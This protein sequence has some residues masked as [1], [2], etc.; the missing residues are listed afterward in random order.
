MYKE[1]VDQVYSQVRDNVI[2]Q[3]RDD[4]SLNVNVGVQNQIW[5][6]VSEIVSDPVI[7][8]FMEIFR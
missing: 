3:G 1:L 2:L 5:I 6:N 4:V 8:L 7:S